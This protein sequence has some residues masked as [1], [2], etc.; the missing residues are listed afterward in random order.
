[1]ILLHASKLCYEVNEHT[2]EKERRRR[3]RIR[4]RIRRTRRLLIYCG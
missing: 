2:G 4:R 1:M 3:R